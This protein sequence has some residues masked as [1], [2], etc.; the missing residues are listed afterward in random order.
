MCEAMNVG[1]GS[2]T[3]AVDDREY[4]A[5]RE[6]EVRGEGKR[7]CERERGGGRRERASCRCFIQS[8]KS[9]SMV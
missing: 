8:L 4:E 9:F 5:V 1:T 7:V 6:G 2:S 3:A